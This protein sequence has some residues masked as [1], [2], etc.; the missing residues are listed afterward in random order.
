MFNIAALGLTVQFIPVEN[1]WPVIV[2]F[3]VENMAAGSTAVL[4]VCFSTD[5][6]RRYEEIS[7]L[8]IAADPN[9]RKLEKVASSPLPGWLGRYAAYALDDQDNASR[10]QM[11][12]PG[13]YTI[14]TPARSSLPVIEVQHGDIGAALAQAGNR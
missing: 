6:A 2:P 1:R 14:T 4:L 3:V 13:P 5:S 9:H 12:D 11:A 10:G 7:Q 8:Y